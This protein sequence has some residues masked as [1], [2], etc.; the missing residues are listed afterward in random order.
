MKSTPA[1]SAHRLACYLEESRGRMAKGRELAKA[2]HMAYKV[3][4][5][6]TTAE[7]AEIS[8]NLD[9]DAEAAD[10]RARRAAK[11][12]RDIAKAIANNPTLNH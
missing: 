11:R 7:I 10:K 2:M 9:R 6:H 12:E 5:H 4:E 1:Q 3:P 8:R